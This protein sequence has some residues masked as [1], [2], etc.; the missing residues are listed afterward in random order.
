MNRLTVLAWVAAIVALVALVVSMAVPTRTVLLSFDVTNESADDLAF[1]TTTLA[2]YNATATFFLPGQWAERHPELVQ[3]LAERY[4]V[5][6]RTMTLPRLPEINDSQVAWE[7]SACKRILE[8]LTGQPVAGF[9][10]PYGLLDERAA[11]LLPELGYAYDA[12]ATENYAWF[13]PTPGVPELAVSSLGPFPHALLAALG[14]MGYFLMRQ[15]SDDQ[16]SLSF[17]PWSVQR[18]RGAFQYLIGSYADAH[19]VFLEHRHALPDTA[20]PA[21]PLTPDLYEHPEQLLVPVT[22]Q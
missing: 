21:R 4:E 1:I 2:Q 17:E 20:E 8:N 3:A 14:D 18:H 5:A 10:A 16:V 12:S 9:R 15:D 7:L 6:C 13:T 19:V 11:A 22:E